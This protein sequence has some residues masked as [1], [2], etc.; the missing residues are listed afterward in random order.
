MDGREGRFH[1]SSSLQFQHFLKTCFEID[2]VPRLKIDSSPEVL[3]DGTMRQNDDGRFTIHATGKARVGKL[4]FIDTDYLG[5]SSAFSWQDGDLFLQDLE[6]LHKEG[7]LTGDFLAQGPLVRY[8]FRSTLPLSAFNPFL[9]EKGPT[10]KGISNFQF[11]KDSQLHITASG[12]INRENLK[13]WD[14]SGKA[15][16]ANFSYRSLKAFDL[17]TDFEISPLGA[18]FRHISLLP[19]DSKEKAR[20][21]FNGPA[22]GRLLA[23][24]ILYQPDKRKLIITNL[25]G[26]AWPTPIVRAFAPRTAKNIEDNYRFHHPPQLALNGSFDC[27]RGQFEQTAFMVNLR[28]TGQTDY[29]FLKRNLPLTKVRTDI[30]FRKKELNVSNLSFST[31]NGRGSGEMNVSFPATRGAPVSYRGGLK[32]RDISF[33]KISET[34]QFD[35]KEKGALTG[36]FDF[37]GKSGSIRNLNGRGF[38]SLQNGSVVALPVFGPLS[39]LIA[40]ILGDKRMG[41]ER[42]KDASAS[43]IIRNGVWQTDDF[44]T[45]STSLNLTGNGWVDLHTD[46]IDMTIRLNARGLL[47]V[48]TLPL[49]PIKGLFQFRGTGKFTDSKWRSSPFTQPRRGK[50]DPL[51]RKPGR[52]IVLPE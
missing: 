51:F 18:E 40:G 35:K 23:D 1:L 39:P 14:A 37:E 4:S 43:F 6:I 34:Y 46:K 19:D 41:Y 3:V 10:A 42:A 24:V 50:K 47:G 17:A 49:A 8:D 22:S 44:L 13:E 20:L 33:R 28:T 12:T 27:R 21:R 38:C 25:R 36:R 2:V 7:R 52:A 30:F 16:L 48:I 11:Q 5:L 15:R 26:T 32:W 31:H 29:T 45:T 9:P